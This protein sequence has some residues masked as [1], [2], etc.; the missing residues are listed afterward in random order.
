MLLQFHLLSEYCV[1]DNGS[2]EAIWK[3]RVFEKKKRQSQLPFFRNT[4]D[5][6]TSPFIPVTEVRYTQSGVFVR[7]QA[8][9]PRLCKR[10]FVTLGS[11]IYVYQHFHPRIVCRSSLTVTGV[12]Y[13]AHSPPRVISQTKIKRSYP[14]L[15]R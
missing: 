14:Q 9:Y 7:P 10:V 6:T 5:S 3:N 11:A 15:Q 13:R 1:T 8:C 12:T 4:S 2:K